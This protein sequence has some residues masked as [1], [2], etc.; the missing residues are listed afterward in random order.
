MGE[1][2]CDPNENAAERAIS[3]EV[4]KEEAMRQ[5]EGGPMGVK[6]YEQPRALSLLSFSE[7]A[8]FCSVA[9]PLICSALC[10]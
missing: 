7:K 1:S 8:F 3:I 5:R 6:E 10:L 9:S 2:G 4:G